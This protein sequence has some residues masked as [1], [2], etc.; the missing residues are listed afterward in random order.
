MAPTNNSLNSISDLVWMIPSIFSR[1]KFYLFF[2]QFQRF[3]VGRRW[4]PSTKS[5]RQK[6]P[7]IF[8]G[9]HV[10]VWWWSMH[11]WDIDGS[12]IIFNYLDC[13]IL[14][15]EEIIPD[16]W[17][18]LLSNCPIFHHHMLCRSPQA[19]TTPYHHCSIYHK[20]QFLGN[21][22]HY[23]ITRDNATFSGWFQ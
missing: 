2:G 7:N 10:E 13:V 1:G 15:L 17:G 16:K 22:R 19:I 5:S 23:S 11:A 4:K 18:T 9:V 12:K 8:N 20:S 14:H 21:I 6:F 3:D